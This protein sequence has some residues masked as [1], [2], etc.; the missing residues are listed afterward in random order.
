L[1]SHSGLDPAS[2]GSPLESPETSLDKSDAVFVDVIHTEIA[3]ITHTGHA[4]FYPNGGLATQPGCSIPDSGGQ[5]FF[6]I[7]LF[8]EIVCCNHCR[9]Q[10]F[11]E[12]SIILSV[13]FWA[14]ECTY[15]E[16]FLTGACDNNRSIQMGEPIP[17][18]Y[19]IY[20][21]IQLVS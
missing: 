19:R 18:K 20:I 16:G 2:Y 10:S 5:H 9:A 13:G 17:A 1:I 15:Y 7:F 8:I 3:Y 6:N 14:K 12:E 11:Y 21:V 4:D